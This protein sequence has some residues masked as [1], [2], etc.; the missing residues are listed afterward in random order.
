MS[1]ALQRS[2]RSFSH[3][4]S[5]TAQWYESNCNGC[6]LPYTVLSGHHPGHLAVPELAESFAVTIRRCLDIP[7]GAVLLQTLQIWQDMEHTFIPGECRYG[8]KPKE[9]A[10]EQVTITPTAEFQRRTK[11]NGVAMEKIQI[12]VHEQYS[13]SADEKLY[14]K[15]LMCK[16]LDD[17]MPILDEITNGKY[18]RWID[19]AITLSIVRSCF[20][21]IFYVHGVHVILHPFVKAF[22]EPHLSAAYAPLR[23][24]LPWCLQRLDTSSNG[25]ST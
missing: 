18:V 3:T 20:K 5:G 14:M 11:V 25:R 13:L 17:S 19:D 8:R 4:S 15:A 23:V 6:C 7:H 21:K 10:L 24:N 1:L 16:L 22:P 2:W 9:K 12:K